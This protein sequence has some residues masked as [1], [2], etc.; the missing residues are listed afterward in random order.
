MQSVA[1][2]RQKFLYE[3]AVIYDGNRMCCT[4]G[5]NCKKNGELPHKGKI[6]REVAF[7]A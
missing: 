4:S 1:T 6:G 7:E 3:T 2:S 5:H